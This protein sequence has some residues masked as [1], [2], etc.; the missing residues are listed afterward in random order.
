MNNEPRIPD[1]ETRKRLS[2]NLRKARLDLEEFGL[3]LEEIEAG[4]DKHIREQKMKR[5]EKS[6]QYLD[7]MSKS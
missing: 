3:Q 5:L 1:E 4:L 7:Q 6:R 2:M